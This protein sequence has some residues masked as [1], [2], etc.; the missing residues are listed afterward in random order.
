MVG[1]ITSKYMIMITYIWRRAVKFAM[2]G[3]SDPDSPMPVR[4]LH[5]ILK[6]FDC[7]S[8]FKSPSINHYLGNIL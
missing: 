8:K 2:F 4:F 7:Q 5:R 1:S 6:H 3:A